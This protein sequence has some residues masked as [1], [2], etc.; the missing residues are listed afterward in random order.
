MPLKRSLSALNVWALAFGGVIGWGSFVMPGTVFLKKAGTLGTLIA[1]EAGA[2]IMLEISYNY[3][4]M[5]KMYPASGGQFIYAKRAF[6]KVHG[7]ICA[8]FLSLCYIC[9]IPMN[10]TA[11]C[12]IFRAVAGDV[13]QFGFHYVVAGYD[14]YFGEI[15][16][17]VIALLVFAYVGLCK[18]RV[19]GIIQTVFAALLLG[20]IFIV[21]AGIIFD[22]AITASVVQPMFY[23]KD[24]NHGGALSQITSVLVVAPWAFVGFDIVPQLSEESSYPGKTAKNIMDTAIL[25]GCFVY[26]VLA[27]MASAGTPEGY[28]GWVE[29][30]ADLPNLQGVTGIATFS[31]ARKV[32]GRFGVACI[33]V[34]AAMAMLTGIV[35]FYTATSRLLYSMARENMLPSWFSELNSNSVPHNAVKFCLIVS[36]LA[37][38]V[39]R[40]ALGWTV[41]MS[42]IGGAVSFA[43]TSLASVF[44]A[45]REKR[46]DMLIF[47]VI[48]FVFSVMFALLLL[49]PVKG[50]DCSL[51]G[52][53]YILLV[54]WVI[55]GILFYLGKVNK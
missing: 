49:V 50:L 31:A 4:Y 20:G 17:A 37:P 32:L 22:K 3:A 16:L 15:L 43:Y 25:C 40:N 44:F 5:I 23:P 55:L 42:S 47:G 36:A 39:G 53:S 51:E 21:L 11:L 41:D 18:V 54:M 27:L 9:I 14:I 10:A 7:F 46:T 6:G 1:M 24:A 33:S 52:P 48:G 29:Y 26:V 19:A 28:S 38:L 13:L 2:L 34:S 30:I 12:L 35:A 45:F 8:W